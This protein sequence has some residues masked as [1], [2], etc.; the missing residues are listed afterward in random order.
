VAITIKD[1]AAMANTST[2]TVSR[3]LAEKPGVAE[4]KR[5]R[6]LELAQRLGYSPNRIAQNLALQKSHVLGLI[7]ADLRNT[8]YIEFLRHIHGKFEEMGYQILTAD[9]ELDPEKERH[10]IS[11]MRQHRAEGLLIFPVVDHNRNTEIDHLLELKLQKFPFVIVGR[12]DGYG[13]DYVTSEEMDTAYRMTKKLIDAGHRR[14]AFVGIDELNRPVSERCAGV[15]KAMSD[16]G[17]H[18]DERSIIHRG[19]GDAPPAE[20]FDLL[21][22][23]DRPTGLVTLNDT[24]AMMCYRPITEMGLRIPED[25]SLVAFGDGIWSRHLIPALTTTGE[26]SEAVAQKALELLLERIEEPTRPPTQELIPQEV[27]DRESVAQAKAGAT[28]S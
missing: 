15:R 1:L 14:I 6:I 25:V 23:E 7:A 22:S 27:H 13:F 4:D 3:V 2:A 9:S 28:S 17:L 16:A 18:L 10:N 24:C 26:N 19:G 12:I 20:L 11:M 5:K 8:M 21:K